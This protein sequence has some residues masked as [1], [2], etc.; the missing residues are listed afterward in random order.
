MPMNSKFR[1]QGTYMTFSNLEPV[2]KLIGE[3]QTYFSL[4]KLSSCSSVLIKLQ[5]NR[6]I[7]IYGMI[8]L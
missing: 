7:T 2:G 8:T 6:P 5:P 4:S 1:Y 3:I